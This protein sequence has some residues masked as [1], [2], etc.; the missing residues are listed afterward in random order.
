MGTAFVTQGEQLQR[1]LADGSVRRSSDLRAVG[2]R[3]QA[4]A[5]ALEAGLV[6]RTATG[7]YYRPEAVPAPEL[8]GL[9]AAC[10]RM[11]RAVACLASAAQLSGLVE[12][13]PGIV[14]VALPVGAHRGRPGETPQRVLR[15]SF[16]GAFDVGVVYKEICGVRVRH[17]GPERTIVDLVRYGRRIGGPEP[18]ILAARSYVAAG[19]AMEDVL[20]VAGELTV[21]IGTVRILQ[22]LM[23][24]FA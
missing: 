6:A 2:I 15:W 13:I 12:E 19:G 23:A 17:T 1:L 10:S 5:I 18:G 24:A 20:A 14:W 22:T 11:P 8:A 4:I 7:A 16:A 9:A 21:P 3:P